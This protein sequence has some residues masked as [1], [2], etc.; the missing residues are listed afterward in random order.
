M[1][2]HPVAISPKDVAR[3]GLLALVLF[4]MGHFFIDLYSGSLGV[5]QPLL[6]ERFGLTFTQAGILGGALCCRAP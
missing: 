3:G 6:L 5:L 1:L 4:S 2:S